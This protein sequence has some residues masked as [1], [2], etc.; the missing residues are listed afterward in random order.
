MELVDRVFADQTHQ[1]QQDWLLETLT[2]SS[3]PDV[4]AVELD[5]LA[6]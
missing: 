6:S 5:A 4:L 3:I 2:S 1:A